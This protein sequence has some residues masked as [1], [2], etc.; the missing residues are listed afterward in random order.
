LSRAARNCLSRAQASHGGGIDAG[1]IVVKRKEHTLQSARSPQHVTHGADLSYVSAET[2]RRSL[3]VLVTRR[4]A[5][6]QG[7]RRQCGQPED[8]HRSELHMHDTCSLEAVCKCEIQ[9]V[10][11]GPL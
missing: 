3:S 7:P 8:R 6:I 5:V 10:G 2:D 11:G 4:P 1:A 9:R